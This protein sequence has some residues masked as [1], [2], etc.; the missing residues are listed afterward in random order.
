MVRAIVGANWGDEGKGKIT[1]MLAEDSD[2]IIR[3]QG[4]SN[5]GHTIINDYGKFAL[6]LLPSG[7]FYNHTTSVIGNGVALNIPYLI[8]ELES[9]TSRNVP[10]PNLSNEK[11]F[12]GG[13]KVK[14]L[15]TPN[16]KWRL[17]EEFGP[18]C[19]TATD[20]GRL[21]FSA[22]YT[23]MENLVTWLM[24]FGAKVEVLEPEE[25]RD[26]IRRNAEEILKIY[27]GLGK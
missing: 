19:F 20:D 9:L 6:H 4:G 14:A 25:V 21:L 7:V 26:I 2:I 15:F 23:D 1:D 10:M 12:P 13:I 27:G 16:M 5:A 3:F 11:I 22:D 8:K 17:V 24:T 18:N